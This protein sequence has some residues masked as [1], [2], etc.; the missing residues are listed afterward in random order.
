MARG[1][2]AS[3]RDAVALAVAQGLNDKI[4]QTIGARVPATGIDRA[5]NCA[6]M[7]SA[8]HTDLN[9]GNHFA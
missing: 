3:F 5:R 8:S 4:G 7:R 9:S 2:L 1:T 6:W